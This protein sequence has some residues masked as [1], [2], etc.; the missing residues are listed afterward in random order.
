MTKNSPTTLVRK[1]SDNVN[2]LSREANVFQN[3]NANN[4]WQS[5]V[6]EYFI[7]GNFYRQHSNPPLWTDYH[8]H[9]F[10]VTLQLKS[11]CNQK[12]LYGVDMIEAQKILDAVCQ[13]LPNKINELPECAN[14]TTEQLCLY[15]A[16]QIKFNDPQVCLE[17]V[18]VSETPERVTKL[19]LSNS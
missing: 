16:S 5:L 17:S 18:S 6:F 4:N 9:D 10:Q 11:V 12:D 15:F 7:S 13:R 19:N 1:S 14:G 8:Y 2:D 3:A